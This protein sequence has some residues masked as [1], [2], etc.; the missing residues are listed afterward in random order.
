MD[1]T[2]LTLVSILLAVILVG[3]GYREYW[4]G[5]P[6]VEPV[7]VRPDPAPSP[8]PSFTEENAPAV[9]EGIGSASAETPI[10]INAAPSKTLERELGI[11]PAAAEAIP[12]YREKLGG[13][14]TDP[15]QILEI[16]GITIDSYRT[17]A[18][19]LRL[20]SSG[21]PAS[22][23]SSATLNAA[24]LADL[25]AVEGIGPTYA[26]RILEERL[27]AGG[28]AS[29]SDVRAVRGIGPARLEAL[30]ARFILGATE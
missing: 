7:V 26:R 11:S 23:T 22:A 15:R 4:G 10:N 27:R 3:L 29:W 18:H 8:L 9:H 28:F 21:A 16:P 24:S 14:Y 25:E 12:R 30:R 6:A 5:M 19:R 2:E 17:F 13:V 1:R 20:D